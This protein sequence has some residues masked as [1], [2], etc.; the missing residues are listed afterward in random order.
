MQITL[1]ISSLSLPSSLISYLAR[2]RPRPTT[3]SHRSCDINGRSPTMWVTVLQSHPSVSMPTHAHDA[4][5]V[6][7]GRMKRAIEFLCQF[8]EPF[9]VDLASLRIFR[10][11]HFSDGV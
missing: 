1:P 3:C 7:P 10:P 11:T 8:L 4:A 5:H 6:A 2:R 9:R